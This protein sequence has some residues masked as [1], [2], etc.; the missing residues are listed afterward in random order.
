MLRPTP[1]NTEYCTGSD[2]KGEFQF[3]VSKPEIV[4]EDLNIFDVAPHEEQKAE[5]ILTRN[6]DVVSNA[7]S[8]DYFRFM[9]NVGGG[10]GHRLVVTEF[11]VI[12]QISPNNTCEN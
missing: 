10:G 4:T 6:D 11:N 3:V 9:K 2:R 12:I 8:G 1:D 5:K 7:Q